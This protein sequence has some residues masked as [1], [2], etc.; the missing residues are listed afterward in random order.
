MTEQK[1]RVELIVPER[2]QERAEIYEAN[3]KRKRAE[4]AF[5]KAKKEETIAR[6]KAQ[7]KSFERIKKTIEAEEGGYDLLNED[8]G[9][10]IYENKIKNSKKQLRK[11][12]KR[13]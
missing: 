9:L 13:H 10:S 1:R 11:L 4:K 8:L 12:K 7:I 3:I 5:L 6:L 2:E